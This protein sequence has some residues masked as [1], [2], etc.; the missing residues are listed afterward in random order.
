MDY[1]PTLREF[2][3]TGDT[4][5]DAFEYNL[6]QMYYIETKLV[7]Q[8]DEMIETVSN[9]EMEEAFTEHQE[10]TET[11]VERL[12]AVFDQIDSQPDTRESATFEGLLEDQSEMMAEME[13]DDLA[14]VVNLGAALQTEHLE[15]A[16][17]ENLEMMAK[18]LDLPRETTK[19]LRDN[20]S[21]EEQTERDLKAL[22]D[23]SAV[24][25][26]FTKLMG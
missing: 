13:N 21:D 15:I 19:K 1:S 23:D 11:H 2:T 22:A 26:V 7:D 3:M 6:E 16:G 25:K 5:H 9:D 24:G 14:D 20:R 8:L 4:L 18:K 17:Y 12:E 10:E